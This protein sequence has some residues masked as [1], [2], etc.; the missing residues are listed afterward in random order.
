MK[1]LWRISRFMRPYGWYV[2]FGFWTT[3][4][5]VAMELSVPRLLQFM[6]DE[7]IRPRALDMILLGAFWMFIAAMIG[8]AST[9]GQGWCRA[10]VSQG[11]AFDLRHA[12]FRHI[13]SLSFANL[14]QMQ[15]GRLMTRV[16]SDVDV[17]HMFA[18]A[19]LALLL[20]VLLM[21]IG[22]MIMLLLTDW[23]LSLIMFAVAGVS[24]VFIR[25]LMLRATSL[26]TVVQQ[27]LGAL[28]TLVQENL[29]GIQVVKAF[30]RGPF[31]IKQFSAS[32]DDYRERNIEVGV[33]IAVSM[34]VLQLLTSVGT[35]AVLWFGG[36]SV[37]G[38]RLTVGEL[39][40]FNNYL[41]IGM[42]PLLFLG[43]LLLMAARAES[44]A[45]R[46][47]EVLD[48]EPILQI[49]DAPHRAERIYGRVV[50]ENVSFHYSRSGNGK[51]N[52]ASGVSG[53]DVLHDISFAAEPGAQV[54]LLGATGSGKSTLVNL[55]PR[56]YD[57]SGGTVS[58]DGVNVRE[59]EPAALRAQ[60]GMVLQ[61]STLFSGSVRD[62]IA[63]GAPDATLDAVIE[64]AQAA[65]AHDFIMA[66]PQG[67]DS[68]VE[69]GGAN[70]SGGQKQRIAIARAL[71][72]RPGIL[73]FDDSTSAVDMETEYKIQAALAEMA[74]ETTT[75]I[76]A[77][78]ITSVLGADQI[79]VLDHGRIAERGTHQELLARGPIYREIYES[80]LGEVARANGR[81]FDTLTTEYTEFE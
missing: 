6:I 8:A 64:A 1:S 30:V 26:F 40:A 62:N 77:Q 56:F 46:V 29:A 11:V 15:T 17:V 76:I 41:M 45:E 66:M 51:S 47:L 28:N 25:Y 63:Y 33:L 55:I 23:Q 34:P 14:D 68:V 67:Y 65:Q 16:S 37:I 20:R 5:P 57:V 4:L 71:L 54:A 59:W 73:I 60:I 58:V 24:A 2:F 81:G 27:K 22:S 69:A 61:E 43:H 74:A 10:V 49:A 79:L 78:R 7:G 80:Q 72:I 42:S 70:L 52:G 36:V 38:D 31:E 21:I 48:T 35:V 53:D 18:S 75:F 13:Q 12:L 32:N 9:L 44:S 3:V 50:F 19:G 39:I